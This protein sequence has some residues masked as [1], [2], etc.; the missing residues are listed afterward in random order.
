MCLGAAACG[1][2]E[3]GTTYKYVS[4]QETITPED[5]ILAGMD[6]TS[7]YENLYKDSTMTLTSKNIKWKMGKETAKMTYTKEGDKYILMGDYV[8]TLKDTM[9]QVYAAFGGQASVDMEIYATVTD[10][11]LIYVM[12]ETVTIT[13]PSSAPVTI[14][15]KLEAIFEKV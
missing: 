5:D 10:T 11:Q 9:Q 7:M 6:L 1:G 12:D 14:Q 13:I 8:K 2:G 4:M 3:K 15:S